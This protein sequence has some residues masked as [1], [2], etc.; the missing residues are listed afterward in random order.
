MFPNTR[1]K[2]RAKRLLKPIG[3]IG[4]SIGGERA[5]SGA[6]IHIDMEKTPPAGQAPACRLFIPGECDEQRFPAQPLLPDRS[7]KRSL[8]GAVKRKTGIVGILRNVFDIEK[9]TR[10]PYS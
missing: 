6:S 2:R 4:V 9:N 5:G 3:H 8:A 10:S 7:Q 1:Q